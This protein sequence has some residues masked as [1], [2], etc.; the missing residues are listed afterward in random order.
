LAIARS[1]A[2]TRR[3]ENLGVMEKPIKA[4]AGQEWIIEMFIIPLF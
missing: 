1:E 3:D 2:G 4:C